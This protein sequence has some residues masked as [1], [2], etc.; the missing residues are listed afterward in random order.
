M[1]GN[2]IGSRQLDYIATKHYN[3]AT[4]KV[5]AM[6][7]VGIRELKNRLSHYVGLAR[8]GKLVT[9][10]D[11]GDEVALIVPLGKGESYH[12][13]MQMVR[14][15][16]ASWGGGKPTG[17]PEPILTRGKPASEIIIEERR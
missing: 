17:S 7:K 12:W 10:T 3:V 4:R 8:E 1:T 11:R 9:I 16:T 14:E 2:R 13:A 15:G 5:R 6:T